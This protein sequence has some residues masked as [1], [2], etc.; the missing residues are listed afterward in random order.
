[1]HIADISIL[2]HRN[3]D[4]ATEL[5]LSKVYAHELESQVHELEAQLDASEARC[6][7]SDAMLDASNAHATIRNSENLA[8]RRQLAEKTGTHKK[9]KINTEG[10]IITP[11]DGTALF[12][13]CGV[14]GETSE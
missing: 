10:H 6:R 13:G 12:S 7:L 3:E 2:S 11:L 5:K 14:P 9:R 8:L 1:M 4:Q